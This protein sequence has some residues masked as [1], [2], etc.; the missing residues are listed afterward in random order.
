MARVSTESRVAARWWADKLR[1][2]FFPG[3]NMGFDPV[4]SFNNPYVL[5]LR[6]MVAE[7]NE[8]QLTEERIKVYEEGLARRIQAVLDRDPDGHATEHGLHCDYDPGPFHRAAL[9]EAGLTVR[10][11]TLPGKTY[12]KVSHGRVSVSDGYAAPFVD[13]PLEA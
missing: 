7:I 12:M 9:E 5:G 4:A 8:D 2:G 13:L 1:H 6:A 10:S 3:D 11:F